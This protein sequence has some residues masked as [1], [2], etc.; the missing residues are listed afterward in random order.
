L[1]AQRDAE[2]AE[3]RANVKPVEPEPISLYESEDER[4]VLIDALGEDLVGVFEKVQRRGLSNLQS[5]ATERVSLLEQETNDLKASQARADFIR[6][7]PKGVMDTFNSKEFQ[8]FAKSER[9]GRKTLHAELDSLVS[10]NDVNN[11][12]FLIERVKGFQAGKQVIRKAQLPNGSSPAVGGTQTAAFDLAEAKK[13]QRDIDRYPPSDS[14]HQKA[15]D[16]FDAYMAL[17]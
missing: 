5:K 6:A 14:R 9:I 8:E 16:Q 10:D 1:L 12:D 3:L 11:I 7:V 13:L 17:S 2:L 15:L 4:Q